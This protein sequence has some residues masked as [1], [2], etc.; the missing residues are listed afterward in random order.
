MN[1]RQFVQGLA[2]LGLSGLMPFCRGRQL[3][4]PELEAKGKPG[5]LGISHGKSFSA[6][7]QYNL[8][9][10]LNWLSHSN[11][12][13]SKR[14]LE[15][16]RGFIPVV[17]THFPELVEEMDGIARGAGMKFEQIVLINARTDIAALVKAEL[18]RKKVPAC[19]SLALFGKN[20]KKGSLALGQNWDWDTSMARAPVI[21]RLS[22]ANHPRLVTL[23]EAGMLAK[24]GFNQH[25][26]GVCLNFLSHRS[27]GQ[28]GGFGIPV[29]CLLRV[30]LSCHS[31]QQAVKKVESS[32]R[33]ASANFLM[34][35]Q[36][37]IGSRALDLEFTPEAIATLKPD[38][39]HLIHTN[40]YLDQKLARGCT[41]GRGP[42]TMN[43]YSTALKL[44]RALENE[45][46]DPVNR[47][48]QVLVSREG[49]PYPISRKGNPDPSSTTLA[50]IIMDLTR[51]R[52]ILSGG[53]PHENPWVL[54]P[55][56]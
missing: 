44:A 8:D 15:L 37:T 29:H 52:L 39:S 54:R 53:P 7:I 4:F 5:D 11:R 50:G 25:R 31:I 41:S 26:L 12:V 19:T 24:I 30:V 13:S 2:V 35:Q 55:G 10:Y 47:M 18:T 51:N 9:F 45:E 34:G 43:R 42:S 27:D 40:H 22:P 56:C 20:E 32:P 46:S 1:R 6:Q 28:P 16:A 3:P 21:L 23:A 38:G 48:K 36:N 17:E 49:I 33:C 14:L